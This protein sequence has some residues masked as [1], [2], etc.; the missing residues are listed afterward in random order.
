[1]HCTH[2]LWGRCSFESNAPL[3]S[4]KPSSHPPLSRRHTMTHYCDVQAL[5][6]ENILACHASWAG[7]IYS[8][9]TQLVPTYEPGIGDML[10]TGVSQTN[11]LLTSRYQ[12]RI[13]QEGVLTLADTL[14]SVRITET[15][16]TAITSH[17][18]VAWL[19][20]GGTATTLDAGLDP[21]AYTPAPGAPTSRGDVRADSIRLA[22]HTWPFE[23]S[24]GIASMP[25]AGEFSP[26]AEVWQVHAELPPLF[27]AP[28][29]VIDAEVVV[30][31]NYDDRL[32]AQTGC[33][34]VAAGVVTDLAHWEYGRVSIGGD[35]FMVDE[36]FSLR[37]SL[38]R[39]RVY[40]TRTNP[41]VPPA[42]AS[43]LLGCAVWTVMAE[44]SQ[45]T[46][47]LVPV[48]SVPQFAAELTSTDEMF[49][50]TG[51]MNRS[52]VEVQWKGL[53]HVH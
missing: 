34:A 50:F 13:S 1:M 9:A 11:P 3:P 38:H 49:D 29:C 19:T 12:A 48:R 33:R 37:A 7:P 14:S 10:L 52:Q 31:H 30:T 35:T 26:Y 51:R 32:F 23:G 25:W 2:T 15:D 8:S 27:D 43:H 24:V 4:V 18:A 46:T 45:D 5:R 16:Y 53:D 17:A 41:Q 44:A 47:R 22:G 39:P 40:S 6:V 20:G 42:L 36:E 21:A 28:E